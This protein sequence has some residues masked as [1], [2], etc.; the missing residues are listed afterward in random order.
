M[1]NENQP[2]EAQEALEER[3]SALEARLD[4]LHTQFSAIE[5]RLTDAKAAH[6]A[7]KDAIQATLGPI[8]RDITSPDG[9]LNRQARLE[10][11]LAAFHA[12]IDDLKAFDAK[13]KSGPLTIDLANDLADIRL[14]LA[15]R[16]R[17]DKYTLTR[18]TLGRL[19]VSHNLVSPE[20][21]ATTS[22][23][24]TEATKP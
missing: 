13:Q 22:P 14:A 20:E 8:I 4:V 9:L 2:N 18:E 17:A 19:M 16:D 12:T 7:F 1:P 21:L 15:R 6:L 23:A 5:D 10:A 24:P 11:G 3:L